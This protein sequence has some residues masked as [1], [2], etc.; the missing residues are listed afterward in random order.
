LY[1]DRPDVELSSLRYTTNLTATSTHVVV[2]ERLPPTE[3]AAAYHIFRARLQIMHWKYLT[4]LGFDTQEW[5]WRLCDGRCSPV[6]T[7]ALDDILNI[8]RSKCH[9]GTR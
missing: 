3:E 8:V 9:V 2:P 5:G 6:T 1:G 4:T 7:D